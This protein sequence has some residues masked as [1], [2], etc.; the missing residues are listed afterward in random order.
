MKTKIILCITLALCVFCSGMTYAKVPMPGRT[1]S[2]VNDY[3]DIIGKD[4][5]NYLEKLI[6]SID[7]K[8]PDPIEVILVTFPSVEGWDPEVFA[9]EYGEK[10][11][12]TKTGRDNGVII[13]VAVKEGYFTVRAG[14]NLRNIITP[15]LVNDVLIKNHIAPHFQRGNFSEGLKGGV[16]VIVEVLKTADIP[17]ARTLKGS[18]VILAITILFIL[19]FVSRRLIK[20]KKKAKATV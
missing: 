11:R 15:R 19:I 17:A 13:F 2:L 9:T 7:Q 14:R 5:E 10:W 3:A 8:T 4:T 16:E 18:H 1:D 12:L 6:L 20:R